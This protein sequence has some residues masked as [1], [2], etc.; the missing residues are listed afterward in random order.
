MN[1]TIYLCSFL[2]IAAPLLG[3]VSNTFRN[4]LLHESS[5]RYL[6]SVWDYQTNPY[7]YSLNQNNS[8][9]FQFTGN[10]LFSLGS[11]F[12]ISDQPIFLT[13]QF[14]NS[15]SSSRKYEPLPQGEVQNESVSRQPDVRL[16]VGTLPFR[17]LNILK[18]FGLGFYFRY[19]QNTQKLDP[20]RTTTERGL[21]RSG[22]ASL[23]NDRE[24][25]S[26]TA[27]GVEFGQFSGGVDV[28][29]AAKTDASVPISYS[30]GIG[31][32]EYGSKIQ[33]FYKDNNEL[34]GENNAPFMEL[35]GG[36]QG[37]Q[38]FFP[39]QRYFG[40]K[41]REITVHFLGWYVLNSFSNI[42]LAGN[43][44]LQPA[45]KGRD[46]SFNTFTIFPEEQTSEVTVTSYRVDAEL[47]L[48][49]DL[50]I[51]F[52][53]LKLGVLRLSPSIRGLYHEEKAEFDEVLTNGVVDGQEYSGN[54]G[55]AFKFYIFLDSRK[56]FRLVAGWHPRFRFSHSFKQTIEKFNFTA[57][58]NQGG[59]FS[60]ENSQGNFADDGTLLNSARFGLEYSPVKNLSL[61][62]GL[63]SD[64]STGLFD[65][66]ALNLGVEYIF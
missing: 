29:D 60:Y 40:P 3:N 25:Y 27:Y 26:V 55:I 61:Q 50:P 2:F 11:S 8:L 31:Y 12:L 15:A 7:I 1:L 49:L 18:N 54:V 41:K 10:E 36:N 23:T 46:D 42:G 44:F 24:N 53:E 20:I 56:H 14:K 28:G 9:S 37:F 62:L 64:G 48:D 30:I 34:A 6:W 35:G 52:Q 65:L 16:M 66:S 19:K 45:L 59:K 47:F 4:S 58:E 17:A 57:L 33:E 5:G 51:S 38:N 39:G 22:E 43:A 21:S 32:N 13:I 63:T